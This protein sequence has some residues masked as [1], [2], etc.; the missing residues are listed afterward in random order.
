[1]KAEGK[2]FNAKIKN[3]NSKKNALPVQGF[4]VY[5][6]IPIPTSTKTKK[7]EFHFHTDLKKNVKSLLI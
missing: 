6:I 1:M 7:N 5:Q 2:N 3:N 4:Y